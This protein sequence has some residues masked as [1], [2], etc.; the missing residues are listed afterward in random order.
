MRKTGLLCLVAVLGAGGARAVS[1]AP[2]A[3]PANPAVTPIRTPTRR[4]VPTVELTGTITSVTGIKPAVESKKP[5]GTCDQIKITAFRTADEYDTSGVLRERESA[6]AKGLSLE[7]CTYSL[8]VPAFVTVRFDATTTIPGYKVVISWNE[9]SSSTGTML[10]GDP[11]PVFNW[12]LKP[13]KG[14]VLPAAPRK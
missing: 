13:I 4:P 10:W 8:R 9:N 5:V 12:K 14:A 6:F 11:N 2:A 7:R 3:T 1:A